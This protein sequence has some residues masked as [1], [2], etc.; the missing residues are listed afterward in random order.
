MEQITLGGG[1][2]W[3]VEAIFKRVKGVK[4][5][6]SGYAG[7]Q[8]SNPSYDLVCSGTT[9]HAEV[10]QIQFDPN[11]IS[12]K[13]ILYIFFKTHDP[14]TV[15]R[16][17]ADIGSQYRSVIFY[18]NDNQKRVA[19][20]MVRELNLR[21]VFKNPIVTQIEALDTFYP[22]EDYH[23]NYYERNPSAGYCQYVIA[24]KLAKADKLLSS[25]F[26]S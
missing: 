2:F 20:Q 23:Q 6:T 11:E 18:Q 4:S 16:Q 5:V 24:P 17:G 12:L 26:I 21:G 1:C 25:F 22:A 10:C 3:C 9:G 19:E 15:N 13:D 7:G 14:T 8:T